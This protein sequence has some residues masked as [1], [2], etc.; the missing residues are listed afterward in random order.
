MLLFREI[1]IVIDKKWLKVF[2]STHSSGETQT[3]K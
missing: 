2:K 1:I 3:K